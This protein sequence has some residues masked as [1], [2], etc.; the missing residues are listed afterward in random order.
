MER[1]TPREYW[2]SSILGMNGEQSEA[3]HHPITG[4]GD[5]LCARLLP[6]FEII[7]WIPW[8]MIWLIRKHLFTFFLYQYPFLYSFSVI[9]F[10]A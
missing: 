7:F 9:N 1:C 3:K 5:V 10:N 2:V 6:S 8:Q 4:T